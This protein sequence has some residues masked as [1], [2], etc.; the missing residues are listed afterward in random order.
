MNLSRTALAAAAVFLVA[1][2]ASAQTVQPSGAPAASSAAT[3][4]A[5]GATTDGTA[6]PDDPAERLD[7][8]R[9]ECRNVETL[10]SRLRSRRVCRTVGEWR[11]LERGTA[12]DVDEYRRRGGNGLDP[13]MGGG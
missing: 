5:T 10:G 11:A 6:I 7:L 8:D 4:T 13:R 3:A 1:G 12:Q 2:A 9:R